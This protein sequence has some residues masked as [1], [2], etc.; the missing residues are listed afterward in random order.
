[1]LRKLSMDDIEQVKVL[2]LQVFS[3]PPWNDG[4]ESDGVQLHLYMQDLMGNP[5]SL[6]FGWFEGDSLIGISLGYVFHW[7]QGT[8]YYVKEF[9]VSV[10]VQGKGHGKEFLAHMDAYLLENDIKAIWLM[11]ERDVPAYGF[12]Q[13]NGFY[14]LSDSVTLARSV[15]GSTS[16]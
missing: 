14:E 5:N 6:T 10:E 15:K 12:Y 7:W 4:W 13:K 16:T 8:D 11:T 3:Q 1:M 2:F 9:C